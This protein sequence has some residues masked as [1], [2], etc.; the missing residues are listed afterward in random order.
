MLNIIIM[1]HRSSPSS[2]QAC[3]WDQTNP[4]VS[5]GDSSQ[6]DIVA[7]VHHIAIRPGYC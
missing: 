5:D 6:H 3:I 7:V 2:G 4:R 1:G